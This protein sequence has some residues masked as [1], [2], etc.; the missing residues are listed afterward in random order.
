[1]TRRG[2]GAGSENVRFD[3]QRLESGVHLVGLPAIGRLDEHRVESVAPL[4]VLPVAGRDRREPT[5]ALPEP[6]DRC[7]RALDVACFERLGGDQVAC[8]YLE[9]PL[10]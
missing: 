8:G 7:G 2:N 4:V 6:R 3:L 10:G 9:L 5:L 1:M